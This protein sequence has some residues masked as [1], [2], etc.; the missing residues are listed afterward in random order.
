MSGAT[1]QTS[2]AAK[3]AIR[4]GNQTFL[5]DEGTASPSIDGLTPWGRRTA[6]S[7]VLG[8]RWWSDNRGHRMC[9]ILPSRVMPAVLFIVTHAPSETANQNSCDF[10]QRDDRR[11]A[12]S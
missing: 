8:Y 12:F 5:Q 6:R 7:R 4:W 1:S 2:V 9:A 3:A 11:R 10:T